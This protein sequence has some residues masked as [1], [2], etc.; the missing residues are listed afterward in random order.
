MS[1]SR[2]QH[3]QES[4]CL[5][6]DPENSSE[7]AWGFIHARR[8]PLHRHQKLWWTWDGMRYVLIDE[9]KIRSEL[10]RWMERQLPHPPKPKHLRDTLEVVRLIRTLPTNTTIPSWIGGGEVDPVDV[11]SFRNG[12]VFAD[13]YVRESGPRLRPHSP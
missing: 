6:L 8:F 9:E 11:I 1:N 10:W 2:T 5:I 13:E 4:P 7:I 12:L 3:E